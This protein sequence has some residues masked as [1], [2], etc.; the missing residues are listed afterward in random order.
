MNH[1]AHLV[2]AGPDE[3]LRLG[4]FL[5]DHV[6]GLQALDELPPDWARGVRLHRYVDS[7]C[8]HHPAVMALLSRLRTPWR[9]YGGIIFD[10]LFD[11]LLTHHWDRFG[12]LPL[13]LLAQRTDDL[14]ARHCEALP[15]RLQRFSAWAKQ[16]NL[17]QRY[18]ERA[19]IAEI[20]GL[21]ARR[22][23]R[24]SPI[25]RGLELL[26]GNE[27]AVTAAFLELFSDLENQVA[28]WKRVNG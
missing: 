13:P 10:V 27:A 24:E 25:A 28:E 5:G 4:A 6:K 15:A 1:L 26:D 8:D 23:G 3:G 22:H 9:R 14:L 16:K 19:M 11:H 20:L 21:I 7:Q 12:P 2:L 17:W 18:G